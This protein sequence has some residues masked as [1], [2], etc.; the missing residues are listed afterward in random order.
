VDPGRH[1]HLHKSPRN[2]SRAY[3]LPIAYLVTGDRRASLLQRGHIERT[4]L[5]TAA[6]FCEE[7]L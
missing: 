7:V 6:I 5:A 4:R 3:S 1:Q 2:K